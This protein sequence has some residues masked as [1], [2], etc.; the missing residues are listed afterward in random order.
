MRTRT[1]LT[2]LVLGLLAPLLTVGAPTQARE[3]TRSG[4]TGCE[5][6]GGFEVCFTSPPTRRDDPTVLDRPAQLFDTAGPGD[7]I[8][9]AMVRWDI[10]PPTDAILAAQ[11]R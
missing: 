2:V 10:K 4:K 9:I 6:R 11:R 3:A 5:V 7:T 1:L 8:R